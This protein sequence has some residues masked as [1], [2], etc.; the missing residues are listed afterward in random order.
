[1]RLTADGLL[2]L[3]LTMALTVVALVA[4]NNLLVLL[5][6][7][8]WSLWLVQ[9]PLGAWNLMDLDVRRVLP[10]ELYAEHDA[11]GAWLLANRRRWWGSHAVEV[12]EGLAV[13]GRVDAVGPGDSRRVDGAWRFP[14]RG[15]AH[16]DAIELRSRWPFG[17]VE[18]RRVVERPAE[19]LVYPRPLPGEREARPHQAS[20]ADDVNRKGGAGDFMGLRAFRE[21]D[22]PQR[23]SWAASARMGRPLVVERGLEQERAVRVRVDAAEG[24]RWERELRRACG[25]VQRATR[26]GEAVGLVVTG[27]DGSIVLSLPPAGGLEGRR[28]ALDTLAMLPERP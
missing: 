28:R 1:M 22:P 15:R 24:T 14:R 2:Y 16:L 13:P 9:W 27:I 7:P 12:L 4:G 18:H 6:A 26:S 5:A 10:A 19:V 17:L 23:I 25:E 3:V 8:M 11:A 20:G 21:G